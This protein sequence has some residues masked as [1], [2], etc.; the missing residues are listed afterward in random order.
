[1][2]GFSRDWVHLATV[3]FDEIKAAHLVKRYGLRRF[4]AMHLSAAKLIKK[5]HGDLSFSFSSLDERL[6]NAAA[7]LRIFCL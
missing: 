2:K 3:D 6:C 4:D 5:G 1:M 7:F